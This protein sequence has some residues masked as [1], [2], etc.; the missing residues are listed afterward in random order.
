MTRKRLC[1][2]NGLTGTAIIVIHLQA[3]KSLNA[4]ATIIRT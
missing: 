3:P 4:A 1:L 2:I